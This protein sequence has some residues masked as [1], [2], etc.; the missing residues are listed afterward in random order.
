MKA[1]AKRFSPSATDLLRSDH[2]RVVALFH[3]YGADLSPRIKRGLV[4]SVCLMLEIHASV[5]E[6]IFYPAMRAV[7]TALVEESAA[8]HDGMRTLIGALRGM[9]AGSVDYDETFFRLMRAVLHHVADE[10]TRLFPD[11]E[12]LFPEDLPRLGAQMAKRRLELGTPRLAEMA[13]SAARRV[14][15]SGMLAAAAGVLTGALIYRQAFRR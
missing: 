10:E 6:E 2:A 1:L 7:D 8:E 4:E 9:D 15:I 14:P 13:R 5:E 12:R 11:A 3:R